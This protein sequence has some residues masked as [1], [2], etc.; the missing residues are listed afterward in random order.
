MLCIPYGVVPYYRSRALAFPQVFVTEIL[1]DSSL[2]D[3][4]LSV[5]IEVVPD[6]AHHTTESNRIIVDTKWK[7]REKGRAHYKSVNR[8]IIAIYSKLYPLVGSQNRRREYI[9]SKLMLRKTPVQLVLL[10]TRSANRIPLPNDLV[11]KI[12]RDETLI[13]PADLGEV[14]RHQ[15]KPILLDGDF[16]VCALLNSV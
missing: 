14:M 6:I 5:H 9:V 13:K 10:L 16:K 12:I 1:D 2:S 11:H 3:S 15:M 8:L 4:T 7:T